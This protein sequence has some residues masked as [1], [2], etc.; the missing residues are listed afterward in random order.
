MTG[1]ETLTN[2]ITVVQ[3]NSGENNSEN[4]LTEPSQFSNEIQIWT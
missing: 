3:E 1:N 2:F 4:L